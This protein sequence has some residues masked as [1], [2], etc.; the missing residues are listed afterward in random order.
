MHEA[1]EVFPG[2]FGDVH[3]GDAFE[4]TLCVVEVVSEEKPNQDVV[5]LNLYLSGDGQASPLSSRQA[6][7]PVLVP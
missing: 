4:S 7:G 3:A 1:L 6:V 5:A 2:S